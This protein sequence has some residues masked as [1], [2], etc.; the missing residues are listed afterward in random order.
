MAMIVWLQLHLSNF[1]H[2][3]L[4]MAWA[5]NRDFLPPLTQFLTYYGI[6]SLEGSM[7]EPSLNWKKK[8]GLIM[9]SD[10]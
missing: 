2:A 6:L 1:W 7:A 3:P 8:D 10:M 5:G 9:F 4:Q